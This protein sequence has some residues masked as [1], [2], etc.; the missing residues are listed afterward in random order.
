MPTRPFDDVRRWLARPA[1]VGLL[2]LFLAVS[3][4]A[5]RADIAGISPSS[6]TVEAGKSISA[7][8]T[9]KVNPAFPPTCIAVTGTSWTVSYSPSPPCPHAEGDSY[10]V[11]FTISVPK[12]AK[13]KT[14]PLTIVEHVIGQSDAVV[15]SKTWKLTVKAPAAPPPPPPPPPPG[16]TTGG[17][18]EEPTTRERDVRLRV[19]ITF[20]PPPPG[21]IALPQHVGV[22]ADGIE[23]AVTGA[24]EPF[25][26]VPGR[27]EWRSSA[28]PSATIDFSWQLLLRYLE[29]RAFYRKAMALNGSPF[30]CPC[31]V[32]GAS[33][34]D[35]SL[36]LAPA[37][38]G[39]IST[40]HGAYLL[41]ASGEVAPG[42]FLD[43]SRVRLSVNDE[44][45]PA[46]APW[47]YLGATLGFERWEHHT[48]G[49]EVEAGALVVTGPFDIVAHWETDYAFVA[50]AMGLFGLFL[51][52]VFG[53]QANSGKAAK[54]VGSGKPGLS[55]W[56]GVAHGWAPYAIGEP[57]AQRPVTASAERVSITRIEEAAQAAEAPITMVDEPELVTSSWWRFKGGGC[58]I[59]TAAYGSELAPEVQ[60]LRGVRDGI[61]RRTRWGREFF[62]EF[63]RYYDRISRPIAAEMHEDAKLREI[64]RWSIVE[65]WSHYM[66]LALLRPE[67]DQVDLEALPPALR[68]YLRELR[69]DM[70]AWI[71]GIELAETF[72]GRDPFDAIEE[73]NIILTF[74]RR[75]GGMEYLD[76]LVER[77][78]LPLT[79][80]P[81]DRPR[82]ERALRDWNRSGEEVAKILGGAP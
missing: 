67:W 75:T 49:V 14:Y 78:E 69:A 17:T 57:A 16:P 74:V 19:I 54:V 10:A 43:G 65:P 59:S 23:R 46:R 32:K 27:L 36:T 80:D 26:Q 11:T 70:D 31:P 64:V 55:A 68:D 51:L 63:W 34:M 5:A 53:V 39:F 33:S 22:L 37:S 20:D 28:D 45:L 73:L 29:R 12:G 76:G 82:L 52:L 18:T 8:V 7:K 71:A 77:S 9:V 61:L 48:T 50:L 56:W 4:S 24:K 2:A 42:W 58:F 30:T 66:K 38:Q 41:D 60:F 6:G 40:P 13:A 35:F 25:R 62:E 1:L 72:G 44:S 3:P 15:D 79:Y 21:V 47:R 81:E